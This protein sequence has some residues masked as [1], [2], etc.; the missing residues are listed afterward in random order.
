MG[1][2]QATDQWIWGQTRNGCY[3]VKSGYLV[4]QNL[5]T[6]LN[7]EPPGKNI[8]FWSKLWK[9]NLC[10]KIKF[11][12]WKLSTGCLST[13]VALSRKGIG[14]G[15][16]C[17][18]CCD[19]EEDLLHLFKNCVWSKNFWT[20]LNIPFVQVPDSDNMVAWLNIFLSEL[21]GREFGCVL[22]AIWW[23]WKHRNKVTFDQVCEVAR[24]CAKKFLF[25]WTKQ[26]LSSESSFNCS[27]GAGNLNEKCWSP[28]VGTVIKINFDAT[29]NEIGS[30]CFY[31]CIAR[32]SS[33]DCIIAESGQLGWAEDAIHAEALAC[34]KALQVAMRIQSQNVVVEGDNLTLMSE[35]KSN[36]RSYLSCG[37]LIDGMKSKLSTFHGII[38]FN[39][40]VREGNKVSHALAHLKL[41][42]SLFVGSEI[43]NSIMFLVQLDKRI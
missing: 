22:S 39:H 25:W 36:S 23:I 13:K 30:M 7:N 29:F 42:D 14:V 32:N 35:L 38:T 16:E 4:A 33:G 18:I 28:P 5:R 43:P 19:E 2:A 17:A 27:L 41:N 8:T 20:A 21:E 40:I 31:G 24:V 34:V 9:L 1:T 6:E 37:G 11:F 12:V 26:P 10:P 15:V 3:S